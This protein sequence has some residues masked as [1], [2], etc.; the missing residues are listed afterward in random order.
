MFTDTGMSLHTLRVD[1]S[2]PQIR[3]VLDC[4]LAKERWHALQVSARLPH[5]N[6]ADIVVKLPARQM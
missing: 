4:H 2:S 5:K 6:N 1:S 3:A